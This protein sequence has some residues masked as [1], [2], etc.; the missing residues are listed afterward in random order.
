[1]LK[2]LVLVVLYCY[3]PHPDQYNHYGHGLIYNSAYTGD[4]SY[5]DCDY[6]DEEGT[7]WASKRVIVSW[8]NGIGT[9]F[10]R[11][12]P[13]IIWQNYNQNRAGQALSNDTNT[14][15]TDTNSTSVTNN[16]NNIP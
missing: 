5:I 2:H 3:G 9:P 8:I 7:L 15:Y 4:V 6:T 10:Q 12:A 14:F 11:I 16:R 13:C 1:M